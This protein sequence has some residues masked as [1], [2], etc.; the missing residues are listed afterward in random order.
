MIDMKNKKTYE[1]PIFDDYANSYEKDL[2]M[3]RTG[4]VSAPAVIWRADGNLSQ[5]MSL[6]VIPQVVMLQVNADLCVEET[7]GYGICD[8]RDAVKLIARR[9]I[10]V[11]IIREEKTADY[12]VSFLHENFIA[13]AF[14]CASYKNRCLVKRVCEAHPLLRG[15]LDFSDLALGKN[16]IRKLSMILS[17]CHASVALLSSQAARKSTIRHLQKRLCTVWIESD[18]LVDSLLRG[19]NGIVT[20]LY[21]RLY[22]ILALFPESSVL[23]TTNLFAH[24]GLHI[25]GEHPENSL[26][27]ITAACEAGL[28]GVEIDIHLTADGHLVVCHNPSTGALFDRDLVI[29][30][31]ALEDL[32]TLRYQSNHSGTIPTLEEVLSAIKKY[33]DTI[34][35]IE[36]KAPDVIKAAEKCRDLI[37]MMDSESQCVFIKGPMLPSLGHLRKAMPDIPAGY[38]VDTDSRV[39][40]A[41]DANLEVYWFTKTTSG[42]NAAYNTQYNRIN[43]RFNQYAGIRGIHVFPWSGT[44][45]GNLHETFLSGYD[46]MTINLVDLYMNLPIE[47]RSTKKRV[48]CRCTNRE[49]KDNSYTPEAFCVY[50]DG[51]RKKPAQTDMLVIGGQALEKHHGSYYADQPGETVLVLQTKIMLSEGLSYYLYSEPVSVTFV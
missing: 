44:T 30:D 43:R 14:V 39:E 22:E 28:D 20:S 24:R 51:C 15:I 38:C 27:G 34:L 26:A 13:D 45:E 7:E 6:P 21:E 36:L 9:A 25:T 40:N 5:I 17:E 2:Y 37:R 48:V 12:L 4:I 35:V 49:D 33:T 18:Y 1:V 32:K 47:L 29:Q 19:S 31:T 42:W 16:R 46:G 50:R 10:P 23:K 3:P 8:L 11:F 41:L